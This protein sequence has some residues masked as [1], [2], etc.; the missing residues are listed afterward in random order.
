MA[1]VS[2]DTGHKS[3]TTD[4]TWALGN[5]ETKV[6]WGWRAMH[7]TVELGKKMTEHFYSSARSGSRKINYSYYSGCSTGGRQGIKEMQISPGSFDGVLVGAPSWFVHHINPFVLALGLYNLPVTDPKHIPV[8]QF[9]M[10]ADAVVQQCD[11]SDGVADGIVSMPERCALDFG[12]ISCGHPAANASNCLTPPQVQTAR[13]I[14]SDWHSTIDGRFL[15]PGL[16]YSSEREW[17]ILEGDI[18]PSAYGT[19]YVQNFLYDDPAWRWQDYNDSV[20]ED[21]IR[22]DPGQATAQQ[23]DV[24][25]FRDRG[26]KMLVYHGLADGLVAT[27]GSQLYYNRTR[28]AMGGHLDEW[29]RYFEIPGMHHCVTSSVGAP[30]VMGGA[31]QAGVFGADQYSVPGF[32]DADH[33]ALLALMRWVEEGKPVDTI[34]ATG[35]RTD[36]VASSG[37]NQQR[38]LCAYPKKAVYAGTGDVKV[39]SSWSCA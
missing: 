1:A 31:F 16:S 26:G 37:V 38:P 30:W 3:N 34:V 33:D 36:T 4:M 18:V 25:A 32:E 2:T 21:A 24:R 11:A 12:P 19:Q 13:N 7:G 20:V 9:G 15:Y 22:L 8:G 14:Y 23:Y 27:K 10:I 17:Y 6:D 39:A 28:D 5:N 29:Y 35:F